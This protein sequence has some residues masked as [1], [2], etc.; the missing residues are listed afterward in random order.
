M[1]NAAKKNGDAISYGKA[2]Q[3]RFVHVSDQRVAEYAHQ[4]LGDARLGELII[5]LAALGADVPALGDDE[6]YTLVV[7]DGGVTLQAVNTWGAIRGLASLLQLHENGALQSSG[8]QIEDAPR[9]AW[10]GLLID[11][12]RHFIPLSSLLSVVDGMAL[13]KLNVLHLHLSDDQGFRMACHT[14]PKLASAQHYSQAELAQLVA[15]AAQLGIRIVPEIDVP[16]HVNCW[17]TAYPQWGLQAVEPTTRFGVHKA[18]LD[19]SNETVYQA[20]AQIFA[21]VAALFPDRYLH[22]GGD[23]VHPAWWRQNSHV[24]SFIA[25]HQLHDER[26][27][28]AYFN[29]RLHDLLEGFGKQMVGW[30]EVLHPQMPTV[31][32]QNWRGATTRD[33]ALLAGQACIVSAGYYL[34]LFYPADLHY[35]YDPEA[36]QAELM[37]LEDN[38][39][40]DLRLAHVSEGIGWT[41][42]WREDMLNIDDVGHLSADAKVLGGE[43]CL[44][45]ELVDDQTLAMRLWSRLPAVAERLWSSRTVQDIENFYQRLGNFL[46]MP[47]LGLAAQLHKQ[48]LGL[49]LSIEQ[50]ETVKM[51]EPVK[52]Y[53]RLLGQQALQARLMGNEMP[54]ARPYQSD[55]PL[56]RVVDYISP[57]SLPARGL[58]DKSESELLIFLKQWQE[59][60]KQQW[61]EDVAPAVRRLGEVATLM[62]NH[63]SGDINGQSLREALTKAYEPVGEYMLAPV[64]ALL[65]WLDRH[66]PGTA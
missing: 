54:Q 32:V 45:A 55:T 23:E 10:R 26:G 48:L 22:I 20:L 8:W 35:R 28:Q 6:T 56:N 29:R 14:F 53:A 37:R 62:L 64:P 9:F 4:L 15:H 59:S 43:A 18:C 47:G 51:L 2:T 52:W 46:E 40:A 39:A 5:D 41:R 24:Q 13:L 30:D 11:V 61:P 38:L 21:E 17:L 50:I 1:P 65:L 12:A 58:T 57:E 63:F 36:D 66:G 49:G 60:V 42:Q 34:D 7:N 25:Q 33:R 44:W 19:V 31:L 16:G 3:V 27:L